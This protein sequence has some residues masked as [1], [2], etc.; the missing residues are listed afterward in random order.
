MCSLVAWGKHGEWGERER[1]RKE[2][3]TC[4]FSG[5]GDSLSSMWE[6]S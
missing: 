6:W 2:E 3:T 5:E 4:T 1:E